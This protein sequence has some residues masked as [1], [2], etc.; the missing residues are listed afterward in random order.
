MTSLSWK[1]FYRHSGW[2]TS[3]C[4][5]WEK[6]FWFGKKDCFFPLELL[7]TWKSQK[8]F[9]VFL[10]FKLDQS[11]F[12]I[13]MVVWKFSWLLIPF[14]S[15]CPIFLALADLIVVFGYT[16]K[17]CFE[18]RISISISSE[19]SGQRFPFPS[20]SLNWKIFGMM[21]NKKDIWVGS[22]KHTFKWVC[23]SVCLYTFSTKL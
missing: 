22:F 4:W 16:S 23:Q 3:K 9:L 14:K 8:R 18:L 1:R 12:F 20:A 7:H 5:V 13:I 2:S 10:T 6:L 19:I 17:I 11:I 21:S 15:L